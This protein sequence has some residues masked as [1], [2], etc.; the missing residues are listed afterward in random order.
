MS[1]T[2][3]SLL[4]RLRISSDASAWQRFV[5]LYQPLM[6]AWARRASLPPHDA[7][8]LVQEVLGIVFQE[9]PHFHYDR[10][11]GSFRSWLRTVARNRLVTFWRRRGET[12]GGSE[13]EQLLNQLA[14]PHSDLSRLWDLEHDRQVLDRLVDSIRPEFE[15]TTWLAFQRVAL[16]GVEPARAAAELGISR[17]AVYTARCRVLRRL[18]EE[19]QGLIG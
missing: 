19:G 9:L 13:V 10:Q 16:E 7:E 8:D 2:S 4:E 17:G 3:A 14:D 11:R 15:A 18:R 6:R 5:D 12:A 1:D